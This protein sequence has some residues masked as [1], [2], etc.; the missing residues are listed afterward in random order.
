MLEYVTEAIIL[1]KTDLGEQDS[2]VFLF[3]KNLGLVIAKMTSGRK[4]ISKLAAHTEP[5][6]FATVRIVDKNSPQLI[7][8]LIIKKT[9]PSKIIFK[10][11]SLIKEIS[12]E[13]QS[14]PELW[15]LLFD[16]LG[17]EA[18]EKDFNEALRILGFDPSNAKCQVPDREK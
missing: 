6:I 11:F 4:I 15:N 5:L 16:L 9:A 14:E 3:T 10:I 2:R 7:D 18:V 13:G 8:A 17:R 12:P 1:D